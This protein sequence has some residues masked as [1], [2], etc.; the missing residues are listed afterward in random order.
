MPKAGK[1]TLIELLVVVAIIAILASLL[2]PALGSAREMAKSVK[3][4]NNFKQ[5]GIAIASYASD[6]NDYTIDYLYFN[7]GSHSSTDQQWIETE[8]ALFAYLLPG[9]AWNNVVAANYFLLL[10]H[11]PT[12]NWPSELGYTSGDASC[13]APYKCISYSMNRKM[14]TVKI[15]NYPGK[16]VFV[17]SSYADRA[18]GGWLYYEHSATIDRVGYRH[19]GGPNMLFLDGSVRWMK[20]ESAIDA[21]L[22]NP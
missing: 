4:A 15:Q 6:N 19:R 18:D 5:F 16:C 1:F 8:G 20:R 3:C 10:T 13:S 7:D 21:S 9:K 11:C 12:H 17:D 2:L 22:H 14:R